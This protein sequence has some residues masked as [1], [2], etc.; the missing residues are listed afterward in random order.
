VKHTTEYI[1]QRRQERLEA[2]RSEYTLVETEMN[3]VMSKLSNVDL[4]EDQRSFIRACYRKK[5]GDIGSRIGQL[6]KKLG[7]PSQK[8]MKMVEKE[9]NLN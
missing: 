9:M 7:I 1:Q 8:K 3:Q 2:D 5:L 6:K 4:T